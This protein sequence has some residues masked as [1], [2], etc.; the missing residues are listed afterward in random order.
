MINIFIGT[1]SINRPD[2][3]NITIP[4]WYEMINKLDKNKF[5]LN[6]V[7][8]IDHIK[9]IPFSVKETQDNYRKL[10]KN[11]NTVFL[12][13]G[14]EKNN[15]F[16]ACK[17]VA[18]YINSEVDRLKLD[19]SQTYIFWLEDD[20]SLVKELDIENLVVNFMTQNSLLNL[21]FLR[22]NYIHALAPFI[23]SFKCWE[24]LHLEAW[25]KNYGQYMDPEHCVGRF[26]LS[27]FY[28]PKSFN[29]DNMYNLSII[30]SRRTVGDDFLESE[31]LNQKN[32]YYTIFN[33]KTLVKR[34][35]RFLELKDINS[36]FTD[37]LTYIRIIPKCCTDSGR[38]YVKKWSLK[39]KKNTD[40]YYVS[41]D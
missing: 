11:I 37:K 17:R 13:S 33:E 8:N 22:R 31:F 41:T 27:K 23:S 35:E 14:D 32:S 34:N 18:N 20:W 9:K 21:S 2:L 29:Y 10:I 30:D 24:N 36:V 40:Y 38:N 26:F 7:I 12:D 28:P 1:T 3:H 39:K 6:W 5:N 19:K 16:N 25:N 4:K 15:F